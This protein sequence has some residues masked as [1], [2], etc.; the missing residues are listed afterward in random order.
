MLHLLYCSSE[1]IDSIPGLRL[2]TSAAF[3]ILMREKGRDAGWREDPIISRAIQEVEHIPIISGAGTYASILDYGIRPED[4]S[5]G[6]KNLVLCKFAEG[7]SR[8]TQMGP[9]CYPYLGVICRDRDVYGV[10]CTVL[11]LPRSF[12]DYSAVRSFNCGQVLRTYSDWLDH[13]PDWMNF[14]ESVSAKVLNDW[15]Q[16]VPSD[17]LQI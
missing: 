7:A 10:T 6:V 2:S 17:W 8:L 14:G 12:F 11:E 15:E 1:E 16:E 3:S 13:R 4:M 5:N 9:N